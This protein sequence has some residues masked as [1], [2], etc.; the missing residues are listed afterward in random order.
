MIHERRHDATVEG[1]ERRQKLLPSYPD[2]LVNP[3]SQV[4]TVGAERELAKG[5]FL[6]AD[7]VHQH[8][9]D[10]DRTVDLNAPSAFERTA[11][12]QVRSVAATF[13]KAAAVEPCCRR[14]RVSWLKVE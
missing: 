8:L 4:I 12:G 13:A 14:T 2:E 5:L 6:G 10:I 1:P 3:R 11:P 7:Y 9:S